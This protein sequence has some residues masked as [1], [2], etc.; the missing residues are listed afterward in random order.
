MSY[1]INSA[2]NDYPM[3]IMHG[4][5]NSTHNASSKQ[6][7]PYDGVQQATVTLSS[8]AHGPE[9]FGPELFV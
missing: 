6:H 4:N 3:I 8:T 2:R 5:I 1:N 7:R 9:A